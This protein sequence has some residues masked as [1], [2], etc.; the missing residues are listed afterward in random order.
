MTHPTPHRRHIRTLAAIL[1]LLVAISLGVVIGRYAVPSR[2][3]VSVSQ[4]R[5]DHLYEACWNRSHP[6]LTGPA[7]PPPM[8]S[9]A[10][11]QNVAM[12][13]GS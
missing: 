10:A 6:G 3:G 8:V 4:S 5:F 9:L 11:I 13:C 7:P 2:R 12:H 1:G